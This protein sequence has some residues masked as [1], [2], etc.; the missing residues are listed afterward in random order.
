MD[1]WL[2]DPTPTTLIPP[3]R[4]HPFFNF[5]LTHPFDYEAGEYSPVNAAWLA[6]L[7]LLAYDDLVHVEA[8]LACGGFHLY[9]AQPIAA[10]HAGAAQVYVAYDEHNVLVAFRGSEI[11]LTSSTRGFLHK[12]FDSLQDTLANAQLQLTPVSDGIQ[13]HQGFVTALEQVWGQLVEGWLDPLTSGPESRRIW[14][15]GHS[16]GGALATLAAWRYGRCA[17]LYT[18]G[19]PRVGDDALRAAVSELP[20][21]RVALKNDFVTT[22]P[23]SRADPRI[24]W[25]PDGYRHAGVPV[26][27]DAG[28]TLSHDEK[29]EEPPPG[30][31]EL[32]AGLSTPVATLTRHLGS[33]D[34]VGSLLDNILSGKAQRDVRLFARSLY[35]HAPLYYALSMRKLLGLPT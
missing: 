27:I 12:T 33:L 35:D 11:P 13:A 16:L 28:A 22:V 14:F 9:G 32:A 21:W 34:D 30:I 2:P 6:D 8:A 18:F 3:N 19:S 4:D 1:G 10:E 25:L 26:H 5:A 20:A 23:P 7:S 15:T 29:E 31:L 24:S 17:G